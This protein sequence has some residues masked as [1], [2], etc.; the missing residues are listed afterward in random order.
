MKKIMV[1]LVLVGVISL[2]AINVWGYDTH[3]HYIGAGGS[4]KAE[5][6][7]NA[8]FES[9]HYI[10]QNGYNYVHDVKEVYRQKKDKS[11]ECI[12]EVNLSK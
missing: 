7:N 6:L 11:W 4:T 12:L 2:L 9:A 8:D 10:S 1:C 5:A 3:T